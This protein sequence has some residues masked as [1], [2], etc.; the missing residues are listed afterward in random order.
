MKNAANVAKASLVP[1]GIALVLVG[2]FTAFIISS[3][4][5]WSTHDY[6]E[7]KTLAP[8]SES[9]IEMDVKKAGSIIHMLIEP[10]GTLAID[11]MHGDQPEFTWQK[12]GLKENIMVLNKDVWTLKIK[13]ISIKESCSYNSSVVLK[14]PHS[15]I[16]RPYLWLRFPL[17]FTGGALLVAATSI[18]LAEYFKGRLNREWVKTGAIIAVFVLFFFSNPI[19]GLIL[20]TGSPWMICE[21]T[22]MEPSINHG[23]LAI[24]AGVNARDLVPNDII[25]FQKVNLV[26]SPDELI[27]LSVPVAHRIQYLNALD[28]HFYFTTQGDSN[29]LADD[30]VVPE[31]GILGKVI[32][33]IPKIGYVLLIFERAEVKVS[34]ILI[35]LLAF[36]VL[37]SLKQKNKH[38]L[39]QTKIQFWKRWF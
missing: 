14:E 6:S 34:V 8:L 25:V 18:Y 4:T 21:G 5:V 35:L 26:A 11:L 38:N 28:N 31:G 16:E 37:P 27:T 2:L 12:T 7:V 30:W 9:L 20:G 15:S 3:Q 33:I 1:L 22:S 23:D 36:F 17:I 29:A 10:N 32:L 24:I 39:S 19:G 13:N